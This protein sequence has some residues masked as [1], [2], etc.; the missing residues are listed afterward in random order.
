MT[1]P[2]LAPDIS[3]RRYPCNDGENA[4]TAETIAMI[5]NADRTI[6]PRP[7]L[8]VASVSCPPLSLPHLY[9]K[10]CSK[11]G[12]LV[13]L[14]LTRE[15]Q[16]FVTEIHGQKAMLIGRRPHSGPASLNSLLRSPNSLHEHT[17]NPHQHARTSRGRNSSKPPA[18]NHATHAA[19]CTRT[20]SAASSRT[21]HPCTHT[22]SAPH[23]MPARCHSTP[24]SG[25][26]VCMTDGEPAGDSRRRRASPPLVTPHLHPSWPASHLSPLGRQ[27]PAAPSAQASQAPVR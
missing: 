20:S 23:R 17:L 24:P 18:L 1:A 6:V 2:A 25:P 12:I 16:I 4:L 15:S 14:D 8:C 26:N 27:R 5:M 19:P 7:L 21:H 13:F 9:T 11:I 10:E 22:S 3:T